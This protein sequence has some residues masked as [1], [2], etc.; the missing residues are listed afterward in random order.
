MNQPIDE[1]EDAKPPI[2]I[3]VSVRNQPSNPCLKVVNL[4]IGFLMFFVALATLLL[5]I[6]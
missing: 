2:I 3:K 4:I 1:D 5:Q 6:F